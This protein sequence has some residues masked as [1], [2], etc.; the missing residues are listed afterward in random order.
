MSFRLLLLLCFYEASG[1]DFV[2]QDKVPILQ[3]L[4]YC[5]M[6]PTVTCLLENY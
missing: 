1:V 5:M 2:R 6:V 3:D 4:L